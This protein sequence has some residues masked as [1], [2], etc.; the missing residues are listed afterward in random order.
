MTFKYVKKIELKMRFEIV[1]IIQYIKILIT[2]GSVFLFDKKS[3]T[4]SLCPFSTATLN[5]AF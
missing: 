5:A 4:I 3:L 2:F 1:L